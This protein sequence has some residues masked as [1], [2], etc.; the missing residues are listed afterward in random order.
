MSI[1][2]TLRTN[3]PNRFGVGVILGGIEVKFDDFGMVEVPERQVV[4]LVEAGLEIVD[5]ADIEKYKEDPSF[6][7]IKELKL[8][9]ID[10][11]DANTK[12]KTLNEALQLKNVNLSAQITELEEK[13]TIS[14]AKVVEYEELFEEEPKTETVEEEV[15]LDSM[16]DEDLIALCKEVKYP[17]KE[18]DKLKGDKL[19]EYVKGKLK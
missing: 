12:L 9:D 13:L 3:K 4:K 14:E 1:G 7:A 16:S 10:V 19:K 8:A 11:H 17:K 2:V 5:E 18:W 15:S 6:D